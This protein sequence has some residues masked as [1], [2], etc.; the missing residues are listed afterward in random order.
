[1]PTSFLNYVF[2]EFFLQVQHRL[3]SR[4]GFASMMVFILTLQEL[5]GANKDKET[6]NQHV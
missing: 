5:E 2:S 4:L 1:M 3:P 6:D